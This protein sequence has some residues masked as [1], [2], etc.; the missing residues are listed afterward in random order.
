MQQLYSDYKAALVET[1][2]A[3]FA[4]PQISA[5]LAGNSLMLKWLGLPQDQF[6]VQSKTNLADAAWM[7]LSSQ[8][9]TN[10]TG[11]CAIEEGLAQHEA[12]YYRVLRFPRLQAPDSMIYI[13]PGTFLMG[14]P[15]NDPNKTP[16]E[17]S[18]FQVTLTRGFW[19]NQFEVTQSEYQNLT[20]TNPATFTGDLERPVESVSWRNAMD[21]CVLLTQH[22]RQ[23]LRLPDGYVYRL[24]TEAEWEY[25]ARAGTT[26]WLSF[27]ND[28][29]LL[30]NYAWYD[31]DSQ[32]TTHP[33]GQLQPN[34]WG[35]QDVH[36][37][38]FEWCWDWIN[39]A[40]AQPVTD[41]RG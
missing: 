18:Q 35:L 7:S 38:V 16:N 28:P 40:P 30:P 23:A 6:Q 39:S 14:T 4:P 19:I 29:S 3:P 8:M 17:L 1:D 32:G 21:Y 27:G 13:P 36:G 20:C 34:P 15:A 25:A 2:Y 26:N 5:S 12:R 37:N 24:P 10:G 22:E 41:F 33:V 11:F 9:I 31:A